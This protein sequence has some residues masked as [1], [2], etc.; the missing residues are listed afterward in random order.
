MLLASGWDCRPCHSIN[1]YRWPDVA[2]EMQTCTESVLAKSR[3]GSQGDKLMRTRKGVKKA[4][5]GLYFVRLLG[6]DS[7]GSRS[8]TFPDIREWS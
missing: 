3:E 6:Q 1:E 2:C 4:G 8:M 5:V 7:R